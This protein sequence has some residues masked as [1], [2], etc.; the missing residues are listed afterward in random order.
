MTAQPSNST[1]VSSTE[2]GPV[3]QADANDLSD[4][5]GV[6]SAAFADDPVFSWWAPDPA[7]RRVLVPQAFRIVLAAT[8]PHGEVYSVGAGAAAVWI[9]PTAEPDE[10]AEAAFLDG[11][12]D[13]AHP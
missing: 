8:I 13:A 11:L 12:A 3:R 7:R 10:A 2:T 6:L 1:V 9:P 4:L 5:V